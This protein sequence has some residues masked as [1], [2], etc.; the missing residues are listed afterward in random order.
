MAQRRK[1]VDCFQLQPVSRDR[2]GF[3]RLQRHGNQAPGRNPTT[4]QTPAGRFTP[5]SSVR[6][7]RSG[8]NGRITPFVQALF[9]GIHASEVTLSHCTG[10]AC[11]LLPSEDTFCDDCRRRA[12][13]PGASASCHSRH[14]SRIPDDP[15]RKSHHRSKWLAERHAAVFGNRLSIRWRPTSASSAAGGL[16]LL[17]QP[18][19]YFRRYNCRL[20][21]GSE[22]QSSKTAVYTWAV[23]RRRL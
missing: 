22:S 16:L 20:R 5:I 1:R 3:R 15:V 14:S 18:L 4:F 8:T 23:E 2:W 21:H 12:R 19:G 6:A 17:G 9:G 13:R 7:C 10:T 11:T